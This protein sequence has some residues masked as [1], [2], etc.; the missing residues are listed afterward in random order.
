LTTASADRGAAPVGV[1]LLDGVGDPDKAD[2]YSTTMGRAAQ[3]ALERGIIYQAA[4]NDAENMGLKVQDYLKDI[5]GEE[6]QTAW[7]FHYILHG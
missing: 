7:W 6:G 3:M 4:E 5:D 1:G 2:F